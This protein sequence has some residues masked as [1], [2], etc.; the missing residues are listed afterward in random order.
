MDCSLQTGLDTKR[1]DVS[2]RS[3][4]VSCAK[5]PE[6]MFR[7][8]QTDEFIDSGLYPGATRA[9]KKLAIKKPEK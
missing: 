9:I 4:L 7:H 1:V 8:Q 3:I 2:I 6:S 5:N